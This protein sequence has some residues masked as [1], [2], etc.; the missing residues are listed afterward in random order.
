VA[1]VAAV[2]ATAI[3][4]AIALPLLLFT[5]YG[6]VICTVYIIEPENAERVAVVARIPAACMQAQF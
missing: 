2:E 5:A 4:I 6:V 3:A 1:A